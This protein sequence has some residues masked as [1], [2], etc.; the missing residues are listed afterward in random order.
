VPYAPAESNQYGLNTTNFP[1]GVCGVSCLDISTAGAGGGAPDFAAGDIARVQI[2]NTRRLIYVTA[3]SAV[4]GGY[5]VQFNAAPR[6]L[7]H[8]AG[9]AGVAITAGTFVQKLGLVTYYRAGTQ[10]MRASRLSAALAPQGESIATGV[11]VFTPRLVFTDGSIAAQADSGSD[12]NATNDYDD[13]AALRIQATIQSERTDPRVNGGRP[14][15]KQLQWWF[16]PRNL[17]Y[18]RNRT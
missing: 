10:L 1:N 16:A 11:Q 15:T 6:L 17:I 13:I 7:H 2:S 9:I 8:A 3:V 14:V 18:E 4:A 12:G 5:R